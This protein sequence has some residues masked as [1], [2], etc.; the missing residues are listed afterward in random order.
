MGKFMIPQKFKWGEFLS[1]Q[2][3]TNILIFDLMYHHHLTGKSDRK[4]TQCWDQ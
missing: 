1:E 4:M 3:G 2:M